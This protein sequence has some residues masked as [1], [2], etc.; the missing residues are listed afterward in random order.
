MIE[1][2][3]LKS[4]KIAIAYDITSREKEIMIYD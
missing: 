1:E 3:K 4:F 2:L